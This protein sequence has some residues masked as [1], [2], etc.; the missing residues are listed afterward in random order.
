[1]MEVKGLQKISYGVYI[2]TSGRK[3]IYNGQIANTVVQ[4]SSQPA[5]ATVSINKQNF[6][7]ELI[8]KS[9]VYGVS[10]LSKEAPLSLIGNF[11][12]KSGREFDKFDGVEYRVGDTGT[13]IVLNNMVAYFETK[14]VKEVDLKTH[15]IFV[16]EIIDA[17]L[18]SDQPQMT[19]DY[20][21][22]IKRGSTSKPDQISSQST[23]KDEVKD[24]AKYVCIACDYVYDPMIGD[25]HSGVKPGT[26]FE[27]LPENWVCPICKAQKS[28]FN[29]ARLIDTSALL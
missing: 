2:V 20:Y 7:H 5:M 9:G 6:T 12:F 24:K 23:N 18:L 27:V 26:P 8:K 14:V 17:K 16:G 4:V 25:P 10:V 11:G 1:M 15:T 13:R 28:Q 3:G 21:H 29:R 19:Y 22:Q